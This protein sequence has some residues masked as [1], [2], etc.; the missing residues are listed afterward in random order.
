MMNDAPDDITDQS[1]REGAHSGRTGDPTV[2]RTLTTTSSRARLR[3]T[4]MMND[5][6][7]DTRHRPSSA[8]HL[9]PTDLKNPHKQRRVEV[10]AG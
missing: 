3:G 6:P 7:D 1:R 10:T 2:R 4:S 9:R 8:S 5:T